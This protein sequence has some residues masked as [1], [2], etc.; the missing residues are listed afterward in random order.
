MQDALVDGMV[1]QRQGGREQGLGRDFVLGFKSDSKFS[2]L[3]PELGAVRAIQ[4]FT[5]ARLL[6][7]L[8]CGFMAC[9]R[10]SF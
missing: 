4:V 5:L 2:D 8:Q 9:H 1:N 7:A 10:F 6:D 3:V